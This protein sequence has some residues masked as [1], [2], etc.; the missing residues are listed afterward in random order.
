[1]MSERRCWMIGN[2]P[3]FAELAFVWPPSTKWWIYFIIRGCRT[4]AHWCTFSSLDNAGSFLQKDTKRI[5][6]VIENQNTRCHFSLSLLNVNT[7]KG[8]C[9]MSCFCCARRR[10]PFIG[11]ISSHCTISLL[12]FIHIRLQQI[13]SQGWISLDVSTTLAH[14]TFFVSSSWRS[15]QTISFVKWI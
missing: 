2:S 9:I 7:H 12:I 10:L 14:K 15:Y 5:R 6:N 11:S 8:L 4:E 3:L 1:M 13:L